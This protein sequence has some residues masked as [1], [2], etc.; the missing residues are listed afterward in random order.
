ME[1]FKRFLPKKYRWMINLL[2]NL[3][4]E[5]RKNVIKGWKN[6]KRYYTQEDVEANLKD[7]ARC[8]NCPNMCR[9]DCP[10]VQISKHEPFAPAHKAR[11][12]YLVGMNHFSWNNPTAI[13]TMYACMGCDACYQWCPMD[14]S[15]ADLLF[16]MRAELEKRDLIPEKLHKLDQNIKQNGSIFKHTP[17]DK[18]SD[19]NYKD[20]NPEVFFYIGCMDAKYHPN[21]IRATIAILEHLKIPFCTHLESRE[22]C[23]GPIRKA[24]FQSTAI[25]L[26]KQNQNLIKNSNASMIIANCP[27]CVD[28]LKNTYE[29][30][31]SDLKIEVK[32]TL[33][34]IWEMI[35]EKKIDFSNSV[36]KT[37]TYHDP[38]LLSRRE[39]NTQI[40][41]TTRKILHLIPDLEFKETYLHGEE[42]QCCGMGGA[43][44]VANPEYSQK[45]REKRLMELKTPNP[46]VILSACPSC[47]YALNK[48]QRQTDTF[49]EKIQDIVEIIAE[50][51]GLSYK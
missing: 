9:F 14:I 33:E 41:D 3:E 26:S 16:E 5:D 17:F 25:K 50:S 6:R 30:F 35:Q 10:A 21:T 22:C 34:F 39:K 42:T 45:I 32:H 31:D 36:A 11:M 7:L 46:D 1:I 15:C 4:K 49:D 47:E 38:C 40:I 20:Q 28:T 23:G 2:K 43:Y 12:S 27:G 19:F 48:A 13:D 18:D 51:I 24:G 29:K 37:A 44:A 8:A